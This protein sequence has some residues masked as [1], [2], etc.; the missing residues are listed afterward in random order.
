MMKL[1]SVHVA[2]I[3]ASHT[4]QCVYSVV[5]IHALHLRYEAG[6]RA[7]CTAP[8][9]VNAVRCDVV[10]ESERS[11]DEIIGKSLTRPTTHN[12]LNVQ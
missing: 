4:M 9:C 1:V 3:I 2:P 12:L 8:T 6:R 11:A 7:L 10:D 5:S